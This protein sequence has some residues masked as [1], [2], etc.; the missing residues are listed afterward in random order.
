MCNTTGLDWLD[1]EY[2]SLGLGLEGWCE[3]RGTGFVMG[4]LD[5]K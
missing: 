4:F 5:T 2:L 1:I 3:P